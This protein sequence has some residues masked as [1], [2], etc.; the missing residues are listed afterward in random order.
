MSKI[1]AKMTTNPMM[2][3]PFKALPFWEEEGVGASYGGEKIDEGVTKGTPGGDSEGARGGDGGESTVVGE[4][5]GA[6]TNY[7]HVKPTTTPPLHSN[8]HQLPT[9]SFNQPKIEEP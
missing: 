9:N 3:N 5:D 1:A 4:W 8:H 7:R 6:C 2:V